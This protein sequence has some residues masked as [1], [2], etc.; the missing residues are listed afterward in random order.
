M[1]IR[2][3]QQKLHYKQPQFV[4][5]CDF[6]LA[7]FMFYC[8]SANIFANNAYD[9]SKIQAYRYSIAATQSTTK[10]VLLPQLKLFKFTV[11]IPELLCSIAAAQTEKIH[12]SICPIAA[13]QTEIIHTSTG[14]CPIAAVQTEIIH[15]SICSI[16]EAQTEMI[17]TV[18]VYV[19]L[20]QLKQK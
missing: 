3:L 18:P 16:T 15:T 1:H 2:L 13:V 12:T 11:S 20:P 14:I 5:I 17:H 10:H 8:C 6:P 4:M 7:I 19:L 9:F